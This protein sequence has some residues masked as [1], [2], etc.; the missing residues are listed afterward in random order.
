MGFL[1]LIHRLNARRYRAGAEAGDPVDQ[2]NLAIELERA[3]DDVAAESWYRKAA[4]AGDPDSRNN[5]ALML[6]RTGRKS[7]A[8]KLLVAAADDD[9]EIAYNVAVLN[10]ELGDEIAALAWYRRASEMG[11]SDA[12]RELRRRGLH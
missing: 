3:G 2:Y 10:E 4:E 12:A 1:A 11:D 9:A 6:D 5:L 8:L 7:E